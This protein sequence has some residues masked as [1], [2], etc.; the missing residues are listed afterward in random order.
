MSLRAVSDTLYTILPSL[1]GLALGWRVPPH[2]VLV[3]APRHNCAFCLVTIY[4]FEDADRV[5]TFDTG[6]RPLFANEDT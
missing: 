4:G 2:T 6:K 3:A 5:T 1:R